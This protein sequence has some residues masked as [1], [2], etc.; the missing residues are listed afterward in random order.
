MARILGGRSIASKLIV[1]SHVGFYGGDLSSCLSDGICKPPMT[2][3]LGNMLNFLI[4]LVVAAGYL[5]IVGGILEKRE[6]E[7]AIIWEVWADHIGRDE[8]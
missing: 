7:V 3:V 4:G 2:L 6:K 8:A 1:T 5:R